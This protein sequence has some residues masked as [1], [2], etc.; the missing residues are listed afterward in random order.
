MAEAAKKKLSVV[1]EVEVGGEGEGDDEGEGDEE[2]EA[3]D[4]APEEAAAAARGLRVRQAPAKGT[5]AEGAADGAG[6][7]V[8]VGR[9]RLEALSEPLLRR[10]KAPLYEVA[11]TSGIALPGE[12]VA[13][14]RAA[15][16]KALDALPGISCNAAEGAMYLFP[17]ILLPPRAV[18]AAS[19][20]GIAADEWYA[21]KV[22]EAT[23]LVVVPGSGFGQAEATWHFRTTFL[24]QADQL[25]DVL[26][27]MSAFQHDF[28]ATWSKKGQSKL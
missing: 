3:G 24:P 7:A 15:T 12:Y 4:G 23:G 28:M 21:L 8:R 16:A 2:G 11:L 19:H 1:R 18:E 27:R 13:E 6:G 26:A 10:L 22:L 20:E 17:Q 9:E 5:A 25:E 14:K